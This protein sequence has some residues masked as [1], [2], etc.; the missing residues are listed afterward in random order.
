MFR[1]EIYLLECTK[2]EEKKNIKGDTGEIYVSSVVCGD[3]WFSTKL[4]SG[5]AASGCGW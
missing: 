4:I 2:G 3:G 1:V 5:D